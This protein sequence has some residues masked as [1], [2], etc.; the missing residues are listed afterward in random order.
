MFDHRPAAPPA[1]LPLAGALVVVLTLAACGA[2]AAPSASPPPTG[3]APTPRATPT[4]VP[5]AS[6]G[7][8]VH[9]GGGNGSG[10]GGNTGGGSDP[11]AG[12]GGGLVPPFPPGPADDPLLGDA[13]YLQ[14]ADGLLNPRPVNVQLV[15][16]VVRDDG[17]ITADLR[18]YSG[19]APC[20][21]LDEVQ[22]QKDDAAKTIRLVVIEGSGPG[23]QM[24]IEIAE[25]HAVAVDLGELA[26]GTWLIA[27]DG[28]A[29]EIKLD[30]P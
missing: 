17:G 14:P 21:Q 24:C 22:I 15:R 20:N 4:A 7:S 23:D 2:A 12:T 13:V 5:G 6:D 8:A 11:G 25:L 28:D 10:S 18:W 19:V 16:A 29:P 3:A 1:R 30:V 9:P 26:S 27:A